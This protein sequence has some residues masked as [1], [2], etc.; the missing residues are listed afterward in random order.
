MNGVVLETKK[1][2]AAVLKEDGTVVKVKGTFKVGETIYVTKK[3]EISP[4][5]N[6]TI[7]FARIVAIAAAA[8][9]IMLGTGGYYYTATAASTVTIYAQD[10]E[11]KLSLNRMDRVIRVEASGNVREEKLQALH[12]VGIKNST[13]PEALDKVSGIFQE[14]SQDT[15]PDKEAAPFPIDIETGSQDK[16]EAMKSQAIEKGFQIHAEM[17]VNDISVNVPDPEMQNPDVD[18][19]A[20][21]MNEH[22]PEALTPDADMTAGTMNEHAPEMSTPDTPP[23][24]SEQPGQMSQSN[25]PYEQY[26]QTGQYEPDGDIPQAAEPPQENLQD[27]PLNDAAAPADMQPQNSPMENASAENPPVINAPVSQTPD[28]N[29]NTPPS[30]PA[31]MP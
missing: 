26:E 13:L 23:Q 27:N 16:Y 18:M 11:V 17:A 1:E 29:M 30:A 28:S 22:A 19:T 10:G 14:T 21:T 7:K 25:E 12:D 15:E 31:A 3:M 5:H 6:R 9:L 4:D 8:L 20:G 24:E 2:Y